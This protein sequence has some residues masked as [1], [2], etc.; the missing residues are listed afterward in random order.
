VIRWFVQPFAALVFALALL[1]LGQFVGD[2]TGFAPPG[3]L[4]DFAKLKINYLNGLSSEIGGSGF[5]ALV[6]GGVAGLVV[7]RMN[8]QRDS[9]RQRASLRRRRK[10]SGTVE[11]K[12][13][14]K[15]GA[16]RLPLA[17]FSFAGDDILDLDIVSPRFF[18]HR[19]VDRLRATNGPV[20]SLLEEITFKGCQ[21]SGARFGG[22]A[23]GAELKH[24]QFTCCEIQASDFRNSRFIGKSGS[25]PFVGTKLTR[26]N[27]DGAKFAKANMVDV[28]MRWCSYWGASFDNSRLP[29]KLFD[30]LDKAG[31]IIREGTGTFR[32]CTRREALKVLTLA[33]I[34][35]LVRYLCG[36][37]FRDS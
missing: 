36:E 34:E 27:F 18:E 33:R 15:S 1:Y 32:V 14:L 20:K 2:F 25:E 22:R 26:C 37:R 35:F 8:R 10:F 4:P 29:V 12:E 16:P 7:A 28:E 30:A 5:D 19:L 9:E 23:D 6:V 11:L 31:L 13:E 24:C 3:W 17:G 21:I